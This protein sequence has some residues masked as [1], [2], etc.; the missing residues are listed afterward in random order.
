MKQ[1]LE[2]AIINMLEHDLN[3]GYRVYTAML[4]LH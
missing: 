3:D 2:L 1:G 4:K